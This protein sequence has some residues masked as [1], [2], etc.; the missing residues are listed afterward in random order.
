[1][2][3][4]IY[5]SLFKEF[6]GESDTTNFYIPVKRNKQHEVIEAFFYLQRKKKWSYVDDL[7]DE[8][9]WDTDE[10]KHLSK[11]PI[12]KTPDKHK[13]LAFILEGY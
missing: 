12:N 1:M 4:Y 2:S 5:F 8:E 10:Y 3:I 13:L 6:S 9:D 11:L 7:T